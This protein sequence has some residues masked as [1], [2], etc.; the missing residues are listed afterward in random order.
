MGPN[1]LLHQ[2]MRNDI[3]ASLPETEL[4]LIR[5]FLRRTRLV[6]GQ[7]LIEQGQP[8]EH[9]YFIEDGVTSLM[10]ELPGSRNS[11][12][13]AM[14]GKEGI[15]GGQALLDAEV[16]TSATAL[17]HIPGPALRMAVTDL[18]SLVPQS[19]EFRRLC[20]VAVA[21]QIGQIMQTSASNARNTLAERCVRW[22]LM[23]HDRVDGGELTVTHE[24]LSAM[25]GVRRSGVTVVLASLVEA[26]SIA[27]QRGRITVV[28]RAKLEG[29]TGQ[30]IDAD[31]GPQVGAYPVS[32]AQ[33]Y[34]GPSNDVSPAKSSSR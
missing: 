18:R 6:A 25:L 17:V 28:D 1:F 3:L 22:L 15:V 7:V 29:M 34:L 23:A 19:P 5:P 32:P 2:P 8:A 30:P 20:S 26:G 33:S 14:I 12:Q 16:S 4:Q 10:V 9:V 24:A 11:V 13:V 27:V 31:P 21:T